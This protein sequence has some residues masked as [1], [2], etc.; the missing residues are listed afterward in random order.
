MIKIQVIGNLGKD[1]VQNVVS[2]KKV[3]NFNVAHSEKWKDAKGE[4]KE[5]TIWVECQYWTEKDGIFPYLKKGT[6]VY[7]EGS[8]EAKS[9]TTK[10]GVVGVSLI[11]RVKEVNLVGGNKQEGKKEDNTNKQ[12]ETSTNSNKIT[13]DDL[14]F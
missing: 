1:A 4:P 13:A 3:I 9:Y 12:A 14:P 8:P 2:E 6:T 7:V 11:C 5:R 10:D